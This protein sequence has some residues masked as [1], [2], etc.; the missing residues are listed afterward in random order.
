MEDNVL[1]F[2]KNRGTQAFAILTHL[3]TRFR[4][5]RLGSGT[6][7]NGWDTILRKK[8]WDSGTLAKRAAKSLTHS[9]LANGVVS[10]HSELMRTGTPASVSDW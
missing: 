5:F 6:V 2:S 10:T 4:P 3:V 1:F 7:R 9:A 8:R